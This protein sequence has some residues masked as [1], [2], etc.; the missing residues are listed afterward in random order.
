MYT[1]LHFILLLN[2]LQLLYFIIYDSYFQ[3]LTADIKVLDY[4]FKYDHINFVKKHF[5][6]MSKQ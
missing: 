3:S 2:I 4:I 6:N 5:W 1:N